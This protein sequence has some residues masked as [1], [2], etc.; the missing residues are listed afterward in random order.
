MSRNRGGV[1]THRRKKRVLKRAKGFIGGRSKLFRTANETIIRADAFSLAHRRKRPG[2]F[3]K[4]WIQ[5]I[6]AAV[7]SFGLTYSR[8]M[9]GLKKAAVDLDR[10]SLSE[11]AIQ[12]PKAFEEVVNKAKVALGA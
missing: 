3:R 11:L 9:S 10:K 12:D 8:F 7:R 4:L 1:P 5:R 6:N 2:T